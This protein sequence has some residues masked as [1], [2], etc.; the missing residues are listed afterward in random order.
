[1]TPAAAR[2]YRSRMSKWAIPAELQVGFPVRDVSSARIT[3]RRLDDGRFEV[4]IEHAK[5]GGVTPTMMRWWISSLD[6]HFEWKG[7]KVLAYR[8]WHPRDHVHFEIFG[9]RTNGLL[10]LPARFH[11]VEAFAAQRRFLVEQ[12]FDV[13]ALD[14]T[15]FHL[16]GYTAGLPI[17]LHET[18]EAVEGG[19]RMT[20]TMRLGTPYR[21]LNRV[22]V[23]V[24]LRVKREQIEAWKRHNVEEDGTLEHFLPEL[25]ARET[26]ASHR[27]A[28]SSF[29]HMRT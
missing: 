11:L 23:A 4:R 15:G 1:M 10:E 21:A 16:R 2:P 28:A 22:L 14:E 20:V 6:Q 7:Q 18:F 29:S 5:L 9:R 26:S 3:E 12:W 19:T 13:P 8:L 27:A 17:E 25:W 24:A